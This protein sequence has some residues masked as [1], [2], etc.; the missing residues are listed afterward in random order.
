MY[1]NIVAKVVGEYSTDHIIAYIVAGM[2]HMTVG[3]DG[4][5][6]CVPVYCLTIERH[7]LFLMITQMCTKSLLRLF[8]SLSPIE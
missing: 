7:K 2:T 8:L 1:P 5:T 4:G 3:V 6:A